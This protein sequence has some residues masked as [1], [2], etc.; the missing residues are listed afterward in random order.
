MSLRML[1]ARAFGI[2][3]V[4]YAALHLVRRS[5]SVVKVRIYQLAEWDGPTC[6]C[7]A[8]GGKLARVLWEAS[9]FAPP[10]GRAWRGMR[11]AA[12]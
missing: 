9:D 4:G 6:P 10:L 1:Q 8:C 2:T 7:D 5:L 12:R 11:R 3:F